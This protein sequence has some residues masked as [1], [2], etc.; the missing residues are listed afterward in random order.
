MFEE[1]S[2]VRLASAM[3]R[4]AT[5]RHSVVAENVANADTPGY[6]ARDVKAF[7]E[8][9][10]EPFTPYTSR[11]GHMSAGI[12]TGGG[13]RAEVVIDPKAEASANGNAV[14]IEAEMLKSV[15]TQGQHA[16][17]TTIYR[18]VHDLMRL[19]IGRGG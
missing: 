2:L 10:N 16:L 5:A 8:Y 4:H 18:K 9:V 7:S 12:T 17:A 1:L 11:P 19:G 6:R 3:A 13:I 14:S 15:E